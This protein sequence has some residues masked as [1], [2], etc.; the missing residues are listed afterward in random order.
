M[1]R[2]INEWRP[3]A[4]LSAVATLVGPVTSASFGGAPLLTPRMQTPSTGRTGGER[5]RR[6]GLS[7]LSSAPRAQ[8]HQKASLVWIR[9]ESRAGEPRSNSALVVAKPPEGR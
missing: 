1:C 9:I 7:L 5:S 3:A 8:P 4:T 2:V 6:C